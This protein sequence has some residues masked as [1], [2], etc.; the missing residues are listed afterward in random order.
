MYWN[1]VTPLLREILEA[2]MN[3]KAFDKFRLVGGTALSLQLGHRESVDI[4][5]FTDAE[6]GTIDFDKID[7]Y[8]RHHYA[9]VESNTVGGIGMGT[10]YFVG[11]AEEN[12]VKLDIYYN[13]PYINEP[14]V[15]ANIRMANVEEIIAMKLE[16][17]GNGGRKKDF[18]DV[19]ACHQHYDIPSMSTLYNKR[20]PYGHT[21]D[22]LRNG[23]VN[24][25]N[26]DDDFDP[27]CLLGKHWEFIKLDLMQ[28]VEHEI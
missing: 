9:Y 10:S 20:Y 27:V 21:E 19:H 8:F 4:D 11:P 1:T 2:I 6:Y 7:A 26:A 23:L 24:F 15:D 5:L 3:E 12:L 16:V 28:W 13:E 18:W 17:I 14:V 22:D 25:T